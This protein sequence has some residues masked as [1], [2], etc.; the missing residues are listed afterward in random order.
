MELESM[1][2]SGEKILWSG[3]P[4]RKCFVFE[5]IFNPLMPFALL[6]AIIDISVLVFLGDELGGEAGFFII[7]FML[8]HMAPVWI[9]LAGLFTITLKYRHE[10]Y[11][12]TDR[13][14]YSSHGMFTV[15]YNT[16]LFADM[17]HV[18][19]HRG[20]FDQMLKVGDVVISASNGDIS[21][22]D[23]PDYE[24]VFRMVKKL[25]E[26]IYSD[27]Q[28][29]NALRPRENTGYRSEYTYKDSEERR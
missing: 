22:I 11:I 18:D 16:K 24:A 6:W 26:D 9:Y 10:A 8:I 5:A 12:V 28:Y 1:I 4:D 27:V 17:S 14:V 7:P 29:P 25:Q 15:N 13:A 2:G 3:R 21:I 19:I 23:I 20:I